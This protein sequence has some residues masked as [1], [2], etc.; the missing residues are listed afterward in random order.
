MSNQP[1]R[2]FMMKFRM[3]SFHL[4]PQ[5]VKFSKYK[6]LQNSECCSENKACLG[7]RM[8]IYFICLKN[9][10]ARSNNT[11]GT[12][13][14]LHLQLGEQTIWSLQCDFPHVPIIC[15]S[16]YVGGVQYADTGLPLPPGLCLM[17]AG[18]HQQQNTNGKFWSVSSSVLI[19]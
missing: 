1:E 11:T 8:D 16:A 14:I 18:D 6:L 12:I 15:T 9:T 3:R 4:L 5:A 7:N 10:Y 13:Y 2:V 17:V 19:F